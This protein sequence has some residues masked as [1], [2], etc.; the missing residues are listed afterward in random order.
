MK[1]QLV[2]IKWLSSFNLKVLNKVY[3]LIAMSIFNLVKNL[4][5][6]SP[7]NLKEKIDIIDNDKFSM[8]FLAI[9]MA[10]RQMNQLSCAIGIHQI[11]FSTWLFLSVLARC[12]LACYLLPS[13]M[14]WWHYFL[15]NSEWRCYIMF[16]II[17]KSMGKKF[18]GS[19][20]KL[21]I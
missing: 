14:S 4:L 3:F 8:I 2:I 10:T 20:F 13:P 9:R 12:L 17:Y 21:I 7:V 1:C 19:L 5:I 16:I 11:M 6:M 15:L 18:I